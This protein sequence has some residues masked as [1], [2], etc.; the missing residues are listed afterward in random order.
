VVETVEINAPPEKIWE[1]IGNFQDMGWHPALAKLEGAGGNA[2]DATRVL[3]LKSG[4]TIAEKL[5]QYDADKKQYKYEITDVDV[6]V[7][8]V[9]NYSAMLSVKGDAGK[10]RLNGARLPR[11]H[12]QRSAARA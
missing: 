6:K 2:A 7:L 1:V 5:I 11:V 8:P 4:G 3:T 10:S 12:E 9:K